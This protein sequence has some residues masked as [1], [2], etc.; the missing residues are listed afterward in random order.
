MSKSFILDKL[1]SQIDSEISDNTRLDV[2]Q[3]A[4]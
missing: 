2:V 1:K 4:S 3:T